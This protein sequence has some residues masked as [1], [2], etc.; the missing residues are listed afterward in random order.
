MSWK[1]RKVGR[2]RKPEDSPELRI[3]TVKDTAEQMDLLIASGHGHS[4]A[5][6]LGS[7]LL[8]KTKIP[9]DLKIEEIDEK[10]QQADL[11]M[12][13]A[14]ERKL[15]LINAKREL[16]ASD[17]VKREKAEA[18]DRKIENLVERLHRTGKTIRNNE[19]HKGLVMNGIA[20]IMPDEVKLTRDDIDSFM[21]EGRYVP[22][23]DR[24]REF[25]RSHVKEN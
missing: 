14:S 10:I 1:K 22:S 15:V 17:E 4:E 8:T 9:A 11:D 21:K 12:M 19:A 7:R 16:Q 13:E 2:P 25:V 23:I 20:E 18:L 5:Y 24:V 3:T 6:R